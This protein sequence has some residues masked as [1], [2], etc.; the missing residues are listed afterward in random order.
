MTV[1]TACSSTMT[2]LNQ[3]MQAVRSGQCEAA[4]VGG[5]MI[6]LKPTTALGFQRLGM[7]SPQGKCMSFDSH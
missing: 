2:A 3:A 5:S 6:S 4:I 1:D 7:L